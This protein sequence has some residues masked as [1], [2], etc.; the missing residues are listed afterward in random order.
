MV[1]FIFICSM[2]VAYAIWIIFYFLRSFK[3]CNRV[4]SSIAVIMGSPYIVLFW[5][6]SKL[7]GGNWTLRELIHGT[8]KNILEEN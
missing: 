7:C 8:Y 5:L 4:Y 1:D 2:V 3:C 6:F